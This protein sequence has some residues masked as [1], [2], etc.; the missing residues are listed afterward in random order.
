MLQLYDDFS[1]LGHS[2][3]WNAL[4]ET[5]M[6]SVTRSTQSVFG[7]RNYYRLLDN[8]LKMID[9]DWSKVHSL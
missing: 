3:Q 1:W 7:G 5:M 8:S 2:W 9:V 6:I 4:E